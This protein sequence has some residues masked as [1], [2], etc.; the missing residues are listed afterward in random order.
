VQGIEVDAGAK[1][2]QNISTDGPEQSLMPDEQM[3]GSA[4]AALDHRGQT[5][6]DDATMVFARVVYLD[7]LAKIAVINEITKA[8]HSI[9]APQLSAL[10]R[11]RD[12]N[13]SPDGGSAECSGIAVEAT[14]D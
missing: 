3:N 14:S 7:D 6:I 13:H 8:L 9:C 4:R 12:S 11:W 1:R 10:E 2:T 5:I